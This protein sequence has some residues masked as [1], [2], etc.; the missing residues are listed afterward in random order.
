MSGK[1]GEINGW[2]CKDCGEVTYAVHVDEGVTPMFLG[3]C[4]SA[5]CNGQGVSLMYPSPPAPDYVIAAV[6]WEWYRPS[7]QW[8]RRKGPAMLDHVRRGGLAF[9]GLTNA[10]RGALALASQGERSESLDQKPDQDVG[11]SRDQK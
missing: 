6:R 3:C 8:A 7:L 2:V 9:R 10:G 1:V 5:T 11:V 4:A